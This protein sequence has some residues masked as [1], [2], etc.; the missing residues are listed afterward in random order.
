MVYGGV[1]TEHIQLNEHS[2]WSGSDRDCP[3]L[4]T[5]QSLGDLYFKTGHMTAENYRR[6]LD[7][8]DAIHRVEYASDGIVYR[9]EYFCSYPDKVMVLRLTSSK[10]KT[11]SGTLRLSDARAVDIPG[12]ETMFEQLVPVSANGNRVAFGGE[13]PN[14]LEY[15]A[16][17]LIVNDG[18]CVVADNNSLRVQDADSLMILFSAGTSFLQ[19]HEQGW[20]GE[21]PHRKVSKAIDEASLKS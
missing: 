21:H 3:N 12:I 11:L 20:L 5:Y 9:R 2:L 4:G 15:E 18:G 6:V 10:K 14:G 8:S 13:L 17:A 16:Q 7:C 1:H 19:D